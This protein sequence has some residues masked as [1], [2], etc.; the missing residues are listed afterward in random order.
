MKKITENGFVEVEYV[1]PLTH[2]YI[3]SHN[4]DLH[5]LS[6]ENGLGG[7]S[8]LGSF[9]GKHKDI[10]GKE[11]EIMATL[12]AKKEVCSLYPQERL[13]LYPIEKLED[14]YNV[15]MENM[16]KHFADILE[17][18]DNFYKTKYMYVDFWQREAK[19]LKDDANFHLMVAYLVAL[20]KKSKYLQEI[21]FD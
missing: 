19:K 9:L 5:Y 7:F 14:G 17:L 10:M 2:E 11:R 12:I 6:M 15:L 1:A 21:F 20:K 13:T 18:N 16:D 3:Q 4:K 8:P